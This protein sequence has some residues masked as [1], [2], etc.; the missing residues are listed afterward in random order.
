MHRRDFLKVLSATPLL[1][2]LPR[3]SFSRGTVG[4]DLL[5]RVRPS[6]P[7]WPGAAS[8]EKLN[9]DVGGNLIKVQPLLAACSTLLPG[10]QCLDTLENLIHST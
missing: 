1:A 8:W 4:D 9:R 5:R 7:A 3:P 10:R 2:L 6:D